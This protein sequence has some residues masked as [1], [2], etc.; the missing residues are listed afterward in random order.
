MVPQYASDHK[1]MISIP[2]L[3]KV[4][5]GLGDKET[6]TYGFCNGV[7]SHISQ[8]M[9]DIHHHNNGVY[10]DEFHNLSFSGI[11]SHTPTLDGKE[12]V[13][14]FLHIYKT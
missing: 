6:G 10:M 1:H 12:P 11:S 9:V 8:S 13:S 2:L 7:F 14:L 5:T 4:H 3:D